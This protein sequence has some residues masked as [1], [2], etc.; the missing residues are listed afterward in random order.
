MTGS[1]SVG[2][3]TRISS[4]SRRSLGGHDTQT[5]VVHDYHEAFRHGER[6][7][8]ERYWAN[9]TSADSITTLAALV[10]IELQCRYSRG[11][12]PTVAEYLDRFP[13]LREV[14]DR[15]V[16]L[17][18]EEF[19]LR[20][21]RGEKLDPDQFCARYD[22]W[23]DSLMPQLLCHRLL[24]QV[25]APAVEPTFP[26]LGDE[27]QGFRLVKGLGSGGV[28]RVYL[29]TETAVGD[30]EVALKISPAR[31]K[32]PSI[33]GRLDHA[34]IV[35]VLS[36]TP[37]DPETGM[38]GLC[39]P[40][41][42]GL[43]LDRV[44]QK[45]TPASGPLKARALWDALET[46]DHAEWE[47]GPKERGWR[48]F[49]LN[50][51]Y[52][53]G[54]A[55]VVLTLARALEH[56]HSRGILHRDV[57]PANVLLTFHDGPQ[58]L[59]FNLAHDPS[60]T[61]HA[62]AALRGGTLPYMAPEQLEALFDS[63]RWQGLGPASDLYALGLLMRELLT[64]QR[65]EAP[66]PELTLPGAI[67][68]LLDRRTRPQPL[69]RLANPTM[70]HALD[71]I[72][73]R[74]LAYSPADRY[75]SAQH[76]IDD[77]ERFLAHRPLQHAPN[78]STLE[79]ARNW[80]HRSRPG[81]ALA[82][83]LVVVLPLARL[84]TKDPNPLPAAAYVDHGLDLLD[85]ERLP[86]EARKAFKEALRLDPTLYTAYQGL[87]KIAF[88]EN[89]Q[90][91]NH[92]Q[93]G[94]A[95]KH[96]EARK[97]RPPAG[98]LA[99]L[100]QMR[101]DASIRRGK[102]EEAKKDIDHAYSFYSDLDNE[103][104]FKIDFVAA[105]TEIGLGD[106]AS[107][108]NRS[109]DAVKHYTHAERALQQGLSLRLDPLQEFRVKSLT[110]EAKR[111]LIDN[112]IGLVEHGQWSEAFQAF[113]RANMLDP[114]LF[115]INR[116]LENVDFNDG[117]FD[118]NYTFLGRV[119]KMAEATSPP[120]SNVSLATL[121]QMRA[122]T[123]MLW[124]NRLQCGSTDDLFLAAAPHYAA[125]RKD[126]EHARDLSG[127]L[128]KEVLFKVGYI[129]AWAEVGLGD[130]AS[131]FDEYE[132][133]VA[134]FTQA[135]QDLETVLSLRL[136]PTQEHL[137]KVIVDKAKRLKG[138]VDR[139]LAVDRPNLEKARRSRNEKVARRALDY[140]GISG[141]DDAAGDAANSPARLT[142]SP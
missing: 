108:F 70:P 109:T 37:P 4:R 54:V 141:G 24:S 130:V 111:W 29:A 16:S 105:W 67:R 69:L 123:S 132:Q 20:E 49:P 66:D 78:T 126:I 103:A 59:D 47:R 104:R 11:E 23:R 42:S 7:S 85:R 74:C 87:A 99:G 92:Y 57:K 5:A 72:A 93:L 26:E 1:P 91:E 68:D 134:H 22:P 6:P 88:L 30:R 50:G 25:V 83:G 110:D 75:A 43:S 98:K 122:D 136:E 124:G 116:R 36:V 86:D 9:S 94:L 19:C 90:A 114:Q 58:L 77:L 52:A 12:R 142:S 101:A 71:S 120:V 53:E 84:V 32:E 96:A 79:V 61:E 125:A 115:A 76:L 81:F 39:M 28:A 13:E 118:S 45:V 65:P 44:I 113:E 10:K 60:D 27:F 18:Y 131:K 46:Q 119:I 14:N 128:D 129:A 3:M 2:L 15:V 89:D 80:A 138:D 34:H 55:W 107:R 63:S 51:T 117:D 35:P 73:A 121:Y 17:I 137:L 21:D 40:Y 41:R 127:S 82:L 8:L 95:I 48:G 97:P 140:S 112:I 31:G 135:E 100:Y 102:Y 133:S 62:Q 33:Q 38:R 56:A 139:R 106:V 64:G